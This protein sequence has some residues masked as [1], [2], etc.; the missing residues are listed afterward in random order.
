MK[1][2]PAVPAATSGQFRNNPLP[3]RLLFVP[4]SREHDHTGTG[5]TTV[6]SV[7]GLILAAG[8][9]QRLGQPKATV[10]F[11]GERLVDRS[12]HTLRS[13]GCAPVVAVTGAVQLSLD[14]VRQVHNPDW[15]SGMGSSLRAGLTALWDEVDAAVIALVDQ[16]LITPRA[17]RRLVA[18]YTAGGRAVVA[19]YNG[20]LRNPVLLAGEHWP[21]VHAMAQGD[22]GAR[23]FLTAYSHL[24]TL[25]PCDDVASPE[26][27]DTLADLERLRAAADLAGDPDR[28]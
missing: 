24:V 23:P 7:A 19:T 12:I 4:V 2:A 26:D 5:G 1:T 27:I 20:Q 14:G 6:T 15:A 17:V 10:Q 9:G 25:V 11:A 18:A 16:P 22:M 21:S 28:T 3:A 13:A 8:Q